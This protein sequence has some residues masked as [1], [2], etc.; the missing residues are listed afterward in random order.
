VVDEREAPVERG[1]LYFGRYPLLR[2]PTADWRLF[3]KGIGYGIHFTR[4]HAMWLGACIGLFALSLWQPTFVTGALFRLVLIGGAFGFLVD[5]NRKR[6]SSEMPDVEPV[7]IGCSLVLVAVL[8][9]VGLMIGG[10]I[11]MLFE[12][13]GD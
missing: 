6:A 11:M 10:S 2:W 8:L 7:S 13:E 1:L 9:F 3:R 5:A 12:T 4:V